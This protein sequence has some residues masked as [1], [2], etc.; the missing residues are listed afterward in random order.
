M[1][2]RTPVACAL[3]A[4]V[5]GASSA[6]PAVAQDVVELAD[7]AAA[8]AEPLS[9]LNGLRELSDGTVLVADGLEGTLLRVGPD[10]AAATPI[11]REG[12]G[13]EEYRTPDALYGVAADSTLMV[14]LGNGRL[15]VLS[16][17]GEV[18][19]SFPIAGGDGPNLTLMIPGAVDA[20]GRVYFRQMP[21]P[22]AGGRPDSAGV[23]RFDP[24]TETTESL[25]KVK[26][27]GMSV[28]TSGGANDRNQVMRPQPLTAE[29]AWTATA[30]G[31]LVVARSDAGAFWLEVHRPD[32]VRSGPRIP[33]TPIPVRE[34][35]KDAYIASLS[36]ALGVSVEVENGRR[37]TSFSRGG[38]PGI[39][40]DELDWPETKPPFPAGALRSASDGTFWLERHVPA[41][42]APRFDVLDTSGRR[43]A[44]IRLP[45][46][47]RL[48]GFG[49][50]SVYLSR[51][52]E[53]DF[54]WLER[55][56]L[57]AL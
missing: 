24:R 6:T 29:D 45:E 50:G 20:D 15:S 25:A 19:R 28:R 3:A 57:P 14:D 11:G 55:Y 37:R 17:D 38:A 44:S 31:R 18:E 12:A 42:E 13:P 53:L 26:L 10:L 43:I 33:Y 16:P 48:I 52:D 32:G 22:R 9:S 7:P 4:L 39:E 2:R 51:S 8:A 54:V 36:G 23:A 35:D 46:G 21:G 30:D 27:P 41:G 56:H 5:A 49:D 34:A 1:N 47:R 40:A